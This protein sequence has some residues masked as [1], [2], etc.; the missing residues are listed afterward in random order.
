[1]HPIMHELIEQ[2]FPVYEGCFHKQ[3][4]DESD[5]EGQH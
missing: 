4:I 3:C 1:M 5:T 2:S